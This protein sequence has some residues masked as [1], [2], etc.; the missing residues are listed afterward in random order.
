MT[1]TNA[2]PASSTG[3]ADILAF[4]LEAGPEKWF[5][6]DSSFDARI[7][8]RF[9]DLHKA[10]AAGELDHWADT[11]EG[12]LALVLVLDQFS[13]NLHRGTPEAFAEDGKA[14]LLAE[15]ALARGHDARVDPQLRKFFAMPFMHA[16]SLAAQDRCVALAHAL[17]DGDATLPYALDHR[18]II[19]RFARFPHRNA[20]L[21]RVSSAAE[22]RYLDGGGFSG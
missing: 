8:E 4:W 17:G 7:G 20:I 9:A 21:G 22:K 15:A 6:A 13:R 14:L 5:A 16:E 12:A 19:R 10:A 3:P 1:D 2:T 18:D 11:P